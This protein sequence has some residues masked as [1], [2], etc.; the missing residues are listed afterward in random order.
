MT[1]TSIYDIDEYD[2][3][4][5]LIGWYDPDLCETWG[6][7]TRWDGNNRVPLVT[8]DPHEWEELHR[9]PGG[10]WVL[11]HWSEWQG[12]AA[13][14]RFLAWEE[15]LDWLLRNGE[16]ADEIERVTGYE[17]P[18]ERG[19]GRPRIGTVVQVTLPDETIARLDAM[20]VAGEAESRSDAIRQRLA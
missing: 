5:T 1:R 18:D 3:T 7:E 8:G 6:P 4:R 10:R 11:H 2:G 9:T 20:V 12:R 17:V 14:H 15:A 19:P 16:P 13:T